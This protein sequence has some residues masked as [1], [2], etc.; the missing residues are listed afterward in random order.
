MLSI[1][2]NLN[3]FRYD[4]F[5]KDTKM[6]KT[7]TSLPEIKLIGITARTNN[8]N[9]ID[10]SLAKISSTVQQ[11]FQ[12]GLPS[13]IP[14]RKKPGITLCAYTDY[15]S[16]MTGDYTY[17]IGE[18]VSSFENLPEGFQTLTIQPQQYAKFTTEPGPMP[19]I[20][21]D[22]WQKIWG[23]TTQDFSGQRSYHADFELYDERASD[24]QNAILDVF[25]GI[26]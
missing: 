4:C 6:K 13:Q 24:P 14:N 2:L 12:G 5:K 9:E 7:Q 20:I 18:E 17:F 16:D 11:Y 19:A 22:A 1:I 8:T 15:E 10:P 3:L 25:I 23:M 26:K 21:I